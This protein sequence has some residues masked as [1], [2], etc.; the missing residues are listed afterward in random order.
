MFLRGINLKLPSIT[1]MLAVSIVVAEEK[2]SSWY[3]NNHQ[4]VGHEGIA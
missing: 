1:F 2:K 4:D 3:L